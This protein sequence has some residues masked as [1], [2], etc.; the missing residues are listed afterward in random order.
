[1]LPNGILI[2]APSSGTGKTTVML[3]LLRAF[4][5][6]GLC[7]QPF[8]SGPDY[9]DPA[10]HHAAARKASFNL[11]SWGMDEALMNTIVAE[12]EDADIAIAEGSM[13]LYDGVATKGAS[14]FGS[15]AETAV[16]FGWP[17]ILVVDVSG[18]AQ[19]AAATALGF[20]NYM[21]D[22][23]FGGVILNR[24]ASPRHERL[25]RLGM[26]QAGIKVL[27]MLPRRGDLALPERHLGL[28]QA[29]EHPDL[30][31][32]ISNYAS[33]L[34]EHVDLEAIRA[35]AQG[36][37][38]KKVGRLVRPPAQRIALARDAAFSFTY[39]HLLKAW[40][41]EGAEIL[42][43]SPLNDDLVPDA[44][45]VWLPG[46]YPELHAGTLAGA[47]KFLTSLREHAATKPVHG[48]CG[49]YMALGTTLIDKE[50]VAHKMAGLLG[51]VTSY[52]KRKFHLGYRQAVLQEAVL[53]YQRG[54]RLRGHE[55]HYST[56]LE[57]P[58]AP[59][60]QVTDADGNL[61]SETGSLRG[62]VSGTFFHM[63]SEATE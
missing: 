11:D 26:E 55:F 52:E 2:S 3:G 22:L 13:G 61:V 31:Q 50:G 56:I 25:A 38:P 15:S 14:G 63:I 24:V 53:G 59:L 46:G 19:S 57:E 28:I 29:I 42:P 4:S 44:D 41:T 7:V 47:N 21:P 49:G 40:R 20:M 62:H 30:E 12:G 16:R 39:P 1:M 54:S 8:K 51:V 34:S 37:N 6:M 35:V 36:T 60:A 45:L 18:Q 9:I 5:D 33:F 10:F 17:V 43:F 27:G 32:A 48:E 58:D 23:P